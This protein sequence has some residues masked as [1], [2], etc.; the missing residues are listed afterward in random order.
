MNGCE[1]IFRVI[2]NVYSYSYSKLECQHE[3]DKFNLL[4]RS[5]NWQWVSINN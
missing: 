5:P 3:G 4:C 1:G 2:I